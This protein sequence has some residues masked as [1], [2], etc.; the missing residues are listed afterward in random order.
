MVKKLSFLIGVLA[1]CLTYSNTVNAETIEPPLVVT[2]INDAATGSANMVVEILKN[3]ANEISQNMVEVPK[4]DS[5]E[6]NCLARNIF[7]EAANETEEG[8]AA[9]GFVTIN[10]LKDERF[11]DSICEVVNQKTVFKKIERI[12]VRA[13]SKSA[14]F[15]T[16]IK[17]RTVCQF[18]WRCHPVTTPSEQDPRWQESYRI[19]DELLNTDNYG[20]LE[21]TYSDVLYFHSVKV[22]PKWASKKQRIRRIGG[23]IF[24]SE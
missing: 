21:R 3:V 8:K 5:A 16:R 10:R 12:L 23:H 15:K 22:K 1:L 20:H 19:A 24:Y 4:A 9:V 11:P 2:S 18:S 6:I 7:Y 17:T 14:A 13:K